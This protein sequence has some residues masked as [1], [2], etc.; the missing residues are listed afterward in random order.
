MIFIYMDQVSFSV[1]TFKTGLHKK[2][3]TIMSLFLCFCLKNISTIRLS[4]NR[5]Q[6]LSYLFP[7]QYQD[8]FVLYNLLFHFSSYSSF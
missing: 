8:C 5:K 1:T 3:D 2:S 4:Q 7:Y 6:A